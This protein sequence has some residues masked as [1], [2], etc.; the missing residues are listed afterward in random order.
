[1]AMD[2]HLRHVMFTDGAGAIAAAAAAAIVRSALA[3]RR[4]VVKMTF[5][6]E[7]VGLGRGPHSDPRPPPSPPPAAILHSNTAAVRGVNGSQ[8]RRPLL[9][10]LLIPRAGLHRPVL[11]VRTSACAAR[12]LDA[13]VRAR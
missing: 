1:M 4:P 2:Q 7:H 12:C 6:G 13:G 3:P 8:R 10:I 5:R 9:P 11:R